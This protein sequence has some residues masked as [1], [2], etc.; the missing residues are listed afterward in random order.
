MKRFTLDEL[1]WE[2]YSQIGE[3]I[4]G[5]L[6]PKKADVV[7]RYYG[8]FPYRPHSVRQLSELLGIPRTTL[9]RRLCAILKELKIIILSSYKFS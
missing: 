9:Q 3:D 1:V 8:I 7:Q 4:L 5:H 2:T 6:D